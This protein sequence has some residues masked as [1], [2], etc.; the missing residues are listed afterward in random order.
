MKRTQTTYRADLPV[1][2]RSYPPNKLPDPAETINSIIHAND[3]NSPDPRGRPMISNGASWDALALVAD[4]DIIDRRIERLEAR[5]T[6]IIQPTITD[7]GEAIQKLRQI[8]EALQGRLSFLEQRPQPEAIGAPTPSPPQIAHDVQDALG[9]M[10]ALQQRVDAIEARPSASG[11]AVDWTPLDEMRTRLEALEARP[12]VEYV[13]APDVRPRRM[14][15]PD[16][17]APRVIRT[18]APEQVAELAARVAALEERP[19]AATPAGETIAP[20]SEAER[21]AGILSAEAD[22]ARDAIV[23]RSPLTWVVRHEAALMAINGNSA[24]VALLKGEADARGVKVEDLARQIVDRYRRMSRS[25]LHLETLE[26]EARL[27]MDA[28][29]TGEEQQHALDYAVGEIDAI[30]REWHA[31]HHH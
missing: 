5:P 6:E 23:G 8:V 28:A 22:A 7:K 17:P 18:V 20:P 27:K 4:L 15:L 31:A 16:L 13:D 14:D 29:R 1:Q 10:L 24:S 25:L 3:P 11:E 9:R 12:A 21:A 30:M 2:L 19:A 26:Q